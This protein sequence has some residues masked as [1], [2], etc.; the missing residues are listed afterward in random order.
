MLTDDE[1]RKA[2]CATN[3]AEQLAN[4]WDG[5]EP[6]AREVERLATER[7]ALVCDYRAEK[8]AAKAETTDDQDDSIELKANAWQFYVLSAEIRKLVSSE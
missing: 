3:K 6:F 7:A 2:F 1:L 5:L 4:G 8:C